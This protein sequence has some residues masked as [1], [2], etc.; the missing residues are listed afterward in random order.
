MG[1]V[2]EGD[3]G[4]FPK[5]LYVRQD[6]ERDGTVF[7]IPYESVDELTEYNGEDIAIYE[8]KRV[9]PLTV[10]AVL[11]DEQVVEDKP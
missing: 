3:V 1:I 5:Q 9:S 6:E 4:E 8:L 10:V 7:F 11:L 2:K